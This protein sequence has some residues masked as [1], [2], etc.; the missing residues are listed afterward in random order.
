VTGPGHAVI[1]LAG[2][3]GPDDPVARETGADCKALSPV[4]GVP[5]LLR[6]LDTLRQAPGVATIVLAGPRQAVLDTNPWLAKKLQDAGIAWVPPGASPSA[7]ALQALDAVPAGTPVLITTADHVLLA[8]EMLAA[9]H[10]GARGHDVAVALAPYRLVHSAYPKSRRTVLRLGRDGGYCGCNLF[11]VNSDNGKRLVSMWRQVEA[12]RKHPARMIV[13]LLGI[14]GVLRYLL[15]L[16]TLDQ[17]MA[18]LSRRTG[19]DVHAVVLT[20]PEAAV[21]VDSVDD[22]RLAETILRARGGG[23]QA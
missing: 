6:V 9:M 10:E 23:G 4:C 19:I 11:A 13:G 14:W 8:P 18:R 1:V 16:L 3:R 21:D 20:Q 17:A 2:D 7:S 15:G 22:L 12:Q 5:M